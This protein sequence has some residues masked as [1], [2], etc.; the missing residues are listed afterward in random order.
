MDNLKEELNNDVINNLEEYNDV[1]NNSEEEEE[2]NEL[3]NEE[4]KDLNKN[5]EKQEKINEKQ[6]DE[7]IIEKDEKNDKDDKNYLK[8]NNNFKTLKKH[9][10]NIKKIVKLIYDKKTKCISF[11]YI[12]SQIYLLLIAAILAIIYPDKFYKI[13]NNINKIIIGEK[14]KIIIGFE[15]GSSQSGYQIFYDSII[16]F[17]DEYIIQNELIFDKFF[18]KGLAIGREAKNYPTK[19]IEL[20]NKLYFTKFKRN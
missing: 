9:L 7:N 20:E 10:N 5:P 14:N 8:G 11:S 19:N 17:K 13:A 15:F 1:L 2:N 3:Q 16:D 18:K 6:N 12:F 4:N